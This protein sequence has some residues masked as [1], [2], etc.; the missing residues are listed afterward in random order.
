MRPGLRES[1][2]RGE[3]RVLDGDAER[4]VIPGDFAWDLLY[5]CV[6]ALGGEAGGAFVLR[7]VEG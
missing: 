1:G 6:A 2:L 4:G 5:D 7:V 3:E